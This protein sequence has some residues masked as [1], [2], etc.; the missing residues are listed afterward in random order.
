MKAGPE[1]SPLLLGLDVIDVACGTGRM[2]RHLASRGARVTGVDFAE[3]ALE[4]ARRET[5]AA[6]LVAS[7]RTLDVLAPAPAE[8]RAAFDVALVVG[9]LTT[10][11]ADEA[12]F[13]R[14]LGHVVSLVRVGG[15]VL[16]LEPI[17]VSRL[18]R[19]ILRLSTARWIARCRAAG[20][21]LEARGGMGFVPGRLA[22][23]WRE[24]PDAL[25]APTFAL[26]E[27][28]LDVVPGAERL[29]DY[30]WLLLRRTT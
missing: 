15:R 3:R 27:G 24:L 16:F 7:F 5:A 6:G 18:L 25:V 1:F 4:A 20:L 9:C 23:A 10:A 11:C 2:S 29:A 26:G 13:A 30:K 28:V 12:A 8:L 22:L 19:R 17:H 14:A 21:A